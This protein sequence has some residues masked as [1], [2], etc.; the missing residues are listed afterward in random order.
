MVLGG[1]DIDTSGSSLSSPVYVRSTCD[2]PYCVNGTI[3]V[4]SQQFAYARGPFEI[5][6]WQWGP[7]TFS[8][9]DTGFGVHSPTAASD[10]TVYLSTPTG[11][12]ALDPSTGNTRWSVQDGNGNPSGGIAIGSDGTVYVGGFSAFY[13]I[14]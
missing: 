4:L 8:Y 10:G 3:G 13:A 12:F 7:Q 2:S 14:H 1:N 5:I 6:P 11:L 9:S